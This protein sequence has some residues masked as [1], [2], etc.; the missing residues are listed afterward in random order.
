VTGAAS[1]VPRPAFRGLIGWAGTTDHKRIGILTG[2]TALA[3][4]AAGGALAMVI[5]AQL[6]E[7]DAH[8]VSQDVYDQVFTMHGSTM[9]YLV[10]IPLALALGVYMVP[11]QVGAA[12]IAA[13]RLVLAGYWLY[14][15]GGIGMYLGFTTTH[16]AAKAGWYSFY[17]LSGA[18]ATP[19]PGMDFWIVG[20][21]LALAGATLMAGAILA[22]ILRLRAPGMTLLRMP[23]FTW[24]MT[25]TTV[26][27]VVS[28]PV[29]LLGFALLEI[30]RQTGGG[31]Y[32][33]IGGPIAYQNLFWFFA[34]PAV[35]EMFFPFLGAAAEVLAVFAGRRWF[36]YRAFVPSVMAFAGLST[37]VWGHHMFSTGRNTNEFF[38]L[39]STAIVIVAGIEYFGAIGTLWL[40]KIRLTVPMLFAIGFFLQFLVGGLSGVVVA[41]PTLDYHLTDSYFI[42]GHFHYTLFAGSMFGLF[43]ALYYWFPKMTGRFL[44]ERLG[45]WQFW[46]MAA[47]TN[48]TF[49]PMLV[50]GYEGMPR[51][52][53]SYPDN[54]GW[55]ALNVVSSAGAA[56][57]AVSMALFAAAVLAAWRR[58]SAAGPDP[59]GGHTLEWATSSPPPLL[60]FAA[61]PPI[62]SYAPLLDL[63]EAGGAGPRAGSQP[64]L[65]AAGRASR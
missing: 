23:V 45:R 24:A 12:N 10:V 4:F 32:D 36:G 46:V 30:D 56:L 55:Q 26:M 3:F 18:R 60:N 62:R 39:T 11:L 44:S 42:V 28:F 13:P 43:A 63:R 15:S 59:W 29:A 1:A 6:S 25:A 35:Y 48:L 57:V 65:P 47:G 64:A 27:T 20:V 33:R 17:P 34:H 22:T 19:G 38:A 50:L 14:V 2:S 5:R 58:P 37:L 49:F 7:P 41:S 61:L 53:A 8:V 31:V 21:M 9:I 16:G 40:G 52:I 54:P 51:R